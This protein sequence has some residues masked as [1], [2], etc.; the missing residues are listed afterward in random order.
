MK[1]GQ[2][3]PHRILSPQKLRRLVEQN[4]FDLFFQL[5]YLPELQK[6]AFDFF[7]IA[8]AA[9]PE[10]YRKKQVYQNLCT[11]KLRGYKRAAISGD[12]YNRLMHHGMQGETYNYYHKL[13]TLYRT[14]LAILIYEWYR[15]A[16]LNQLSL[17]LEANANQVTIT[18]GRITRLNQQVSFYLQLTKALC[19]TFSPADEEEYEAYSS[20]EETLNRMEMC[21]Y[22][23]IR[24]RDAAVIDTTRLRRLTRQQQMQ[25]A[26]ILDFCSNYSGGDHLETLTR[27]QR[28]DWRKILQLLHA[29]PEESDIADLLQDQYPI[30]YKAETLFQKG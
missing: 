11:Q 24:E 9:T 25:V 28:N 29:L 12:L 27:R 14:L 17:E 8:N 4:P 6:I 2:K 18:P 26:K 5:C 16:S 19:Q 23:G 13:P 3:G 1:N 7:E 22:F 15:S 21:L 30:L 20:I 10:G